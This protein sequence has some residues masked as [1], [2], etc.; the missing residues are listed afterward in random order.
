LLG[1]RWLVSVLQWAV[2]IVV[3]GASCQGDDSPLTVT[4]VT[5]RAFFALMGGMTN[6]RAKSRFLSGSALWARKRIKIAVK[7]V[8]KLADGRRRTVGYDGPRN[9]FLPSPAKL[10]FCSLGALESDLPGC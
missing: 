9:M 4:T 6:T 5:V 2:W 8:L 1:V 7:G 10:I 3:I